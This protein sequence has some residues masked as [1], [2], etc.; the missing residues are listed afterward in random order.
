MAK[1]S[2][3][4]LS[5]HYTDSGQGVPVVLLHG[6]LEDLS[7]WNYLGPSLSSKYRVICIDLLGHGKT[8]NLG[9]VHT[10]EEQAEMVSYVLECLEVD[11]TSLVGHSMG[12][13]VALAYAEMFPNRVRSLCLMNSTALSDDPERRKNRDRGI[14]AVKQNHRTFV[15]LAI[16]N[17]FAEKNRSRYKEEIA[18]ITR[19]GLHMTAQGIIA[20]LEGMKAR[21]DRTQVL[22]EASFPRLLI[23][24]EMDPALPYD[25]LQSQMRIQGVFS[26]VFPDGHM[27]HIENTADL[28]AAVHEFL[29]RT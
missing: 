3:K 18:A 23:I 11:C 16:P 28:E 7:M 13:Y 17:L 8:D 20:S 6:F 21:P 22:T 1:L 19:Q 27:S 15:R 24:G 14:E 4:N 29:L 26:V 9:Y 10:M 25:S 2:Y 5:V 12:G